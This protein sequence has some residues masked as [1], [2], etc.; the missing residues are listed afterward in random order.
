[1]VLA[2]FMLLDQQ[3]GIPC[4]R[5]CRTIHSPINSSITD[6]KWRSS[7]KHITRHSKFV[8]AQAGRS[9][10]VKY[11]SELAL[12]FCWIRDFMKDWNH[13]SH[14]RHGLMYCS[15]MYHIVMLVTLFSFHTTYFLTSWQRAEWWTAEFSA[16]L[17]DKINDFNWMSTKSVVTSA[18]SSMSS[19]APVW[20]NGW[21][22]T[23]CFSTS[24]NST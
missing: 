10:K 4:H 15:V 11:T 6:S 23:D 3:H 1:M 18:R 2:A 20:L 22:P 16:T 12:K 9:M 19:P 17:I 8:A 7:V 5:M 24:Y 21:N 13:V 14:S